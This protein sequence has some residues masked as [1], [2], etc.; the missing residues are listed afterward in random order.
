MPHDREAE[1]EAALRARARGI[2]LP[3]RFE[4][5]A[6]ELRRDA[7]AGIADPDHGVRAR[8]VEGQG[9]ASISRR[10]LDGVGEQVPDDLLEPAGVTGERP[11][12]DELRVE[13]DALRLRQRPHAV[14]GG[15]DD[16]D[17]IDRPAVQPEL[18]GDQARDVEEIFDEL[19]LQLRVELD[20]G[21][22][23][24]DARLIELPRA[25]QPRPPEDG[26]QRRAELVR[27]RREEL[28]R[29]GRSPRQASGLPARSGGPRS[30]TER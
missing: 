24:C 2:R 13:L 23:A 12:S 27:Q 9:D 8:A 26:A 25:Q 3:E 16:R 11:G 1:P 14:D 29:A 6:E 17:Q 7:A 20:R 22:C 5:P 18:S 15:L 19:H 21:E 28:V 10:E 30:W 4:D